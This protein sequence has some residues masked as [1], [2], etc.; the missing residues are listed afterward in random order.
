VPI[1]VNEKPVKTIPY[2]EQIKSDSMLKIRENFVDLVIYQT[3]QT[4]AAQ[5][6]KKPKLKNQQI[7]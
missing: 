1:F 2:R 5:N 3:D 6:P 4:Y 7:I